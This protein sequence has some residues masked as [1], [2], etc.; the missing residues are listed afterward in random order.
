MPITALS[1][2][3]R[4][5]VLV[6]AVRLRCCARCVLALACAPGQQPM[7]GNHD[8]PGS[9]PTIIY[10]CLQTRHSHARTCI[11]LRGHVHGDARHGPQRGNQ[12]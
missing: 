2:R 6:P 3:A 7:P 12:T 1:M 11:S 10:A 4:V 9:T 5:Y 8:A